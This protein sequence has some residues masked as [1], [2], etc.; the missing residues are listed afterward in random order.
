[1]SSIDSKEYRELFLIE[2]NEHLQNINNELL[3]YE[4]DHAKERVDSIFRSVHT[5]KGM[6]ATMGYENIKILCKSIENVLDALRNDKLML[7]KVVID[8]LFASIDVLTKLV[9]DENALIDIS[10]HI[11]ILAD[12]IESNQN[13]GIKEKVENTHT[14]E[15]IQD[16]LPPTITIKLEDIDKMVDLVG[17]LV[18][19]KMRLENSLQPYLD[20]RMN[21]VL[22]QFSR[23][24]SDLQ[25]NVM[26]LRLVPLSIIFNRF[27]RL[28]RDTASKLG[29][30][31]RL[32]VKGSELEIDRSI[33]QAISDP[34]VHI[35][36]NAID[37]GIEM[38]EERLQNGKDRVG[39]IR[40]VALR[41]GEMISITVE[42]DG[43]GIDADALKAKAVERGIISKEE[44]ERMSDED[45]FKLLGTPGLSTAKQVTDISGRGV[46]MDV[47]FKQ[48]SRFGGYVSINSKRGLGTSITLN[49]PLNVSIISGLLIYVNE[50]RYIIPS[51]NVARTLKVSSTDIMHIH[52]R[53]VIRVKDKDG[54]DEGIIPLLD[55][56][57]ILNCYRD[58]NNDNSNEFS[59]VVVNSKGKYI[60]LIVDRFEYIKEMVVKHIIGIDGK[61]KEATIIGDGTPILILDIAQLINNNY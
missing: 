14:D 56:S 21:M 20:G 61:F 8:T 44:A 13:N 17:E 42:D 55:M 30:E 16:K 23:L 27:H 31:V 43:K 28:V 9:N 25:F 47:V 37:H 53:R 36:R 29:K 22:A 32:E 54:R 10:N 46:G 11:K 15:S 7:S 50:E 52:G 33:M 51:S 6:A 60:G 1:M 2:A 5:I 40:I 59:I 57:Y 58:S 4:K 26:K 39:L 24:I 18:I 12:L 48:V 49:I 41:M 3:E 19:A 35:I 34:L 45:A 38:P